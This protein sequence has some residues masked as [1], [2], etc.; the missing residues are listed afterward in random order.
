[1]NNRVNFII[2]SFVLLLASSANWGQQQI[3]SDYKN[4][5]GPKYKVGLS[6]ELVGK[7]NEISIQISLDKKYFNQNDMVKLA[8]K[9][10]ATYRKYDVIYAVLYDNYKESRDPANT[11]I[12]LKSNMKTVRMRGFY[13][14]DKKTGEDALEYSLKAGE[15]TDQVQLRFKN[16]HLLE[17]HSKE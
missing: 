1:M 6:T 17:V 4:V 13:H 9:L 15:R 11:F 14:L 3:V 2:A 10:R 7:P 16:G 12:M 8:G 5:S